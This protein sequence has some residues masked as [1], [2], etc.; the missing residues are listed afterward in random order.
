MK[1]GAH[2][3]RGGIGPVVLRRTTQRIREGS[4]MCLGV[5]DK[6]SQLRL[7]RRGVRVRVRASP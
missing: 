6:K 5:L 1:L 7:K 3:E 2:V 4:R